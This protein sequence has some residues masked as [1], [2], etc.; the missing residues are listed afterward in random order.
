M[1]DTYRRTLCVPNADDWEPMRVR[2]TANADLDA[3]GAKLVYQCWSGIT[4]R[5]LYR[6]T[7]QADDCASTR[8]DHI[9]VRALVE[10]GGAS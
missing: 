2:D 6:P 1:I 4:V 9:L 3:M 5:W 10:R 7:E 8:H